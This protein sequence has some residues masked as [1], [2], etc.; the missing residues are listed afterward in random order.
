MQPKQCLEPETQLVLA[1]DIGSSSVR[2]RAFDLNADLLPGVTSQIHY[3]MESSSDGG[4]EIDADYLLDI[5]ASSLDDVLL[6]AGSRSERIRWVGVSA[7]WHSLLGVDEFGK[8]VTRVLSWNDTRASGAAVQLRENLDEVEVR[9]RTGCPLHA[10]YAPAKILWLAQSHPALIHASRRWMSFAEYFYLRLF[11]EAGSSVSMA[12]ASGLFNQNLIDWDEPILAA[13]PIGRHNLAPIVDDNA[14]CSGLREEFAS[15]WPALNNAEWFPAIGDGACGNIGMGCIDSSRIALMIGTSAAMR[16]VVS[17]ARAEVPPGLWSYRVDRSRR[18]IGG[19]LSNGGDV[20]AW[21]SRTLRLP[22]AE[23]LEQ[24][25]STMAPDAHGLTMLP[26]FSGERSTGWASEARAV[27]AGLTLSTTPAEIARAGLEAVAYR[28]ADIYDRMSEV[29]EP[30]HRVIAGGAALL[31]SRAWT[32]II[33]DVLGIPISVSAAGEASCRGAAL[34]ALEQAGVLEAGE[35]APP[36][37]LETIRPSEEAHMQYLLARQRQELL[38][39]Q[40]VE[41]RGANRVAGAEIAVAL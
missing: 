41:S 38:Y 34:W 20:Y 21:L 18:V 23:A 40:V 14:R 36:A 12:S 1:V 6:K 9:A 10:S 31:S 8:P 3:S 27:I 4:F 17:P 24:E 5:V 26:F 32:Q 11:G 16:A 7:F 13:L 28:I 39:G 22:E 30:H 33:A 35:S 19:A 37:I 25:I 2:A 15:R 29:A